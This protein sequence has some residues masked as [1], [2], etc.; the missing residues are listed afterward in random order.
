MIETLPGLGSFLV[1]RLKFSH[2]ER[3]ESR[4]TG[5]RWG[6]QNGVRL[7]HVGDKSVVVEQTQ[8]TVCKHELCSHSRFSLCVYSCRKG[9]GSPL[10]GHGSRLTWNLCLGNWSLLICFPGGP[11]GK[12]TAC[13]Y[14]KHKRYGFDPWVGKILWRRAWQTTP[15][16]LPENPVDRRA[17]KILRFW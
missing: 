6:W 5:L 10:R 1:S 16:L 13:Q 8:T 12:E 11:S 4:S 2:A 15:G 17:C 7:A 14:R 3:G 9:G